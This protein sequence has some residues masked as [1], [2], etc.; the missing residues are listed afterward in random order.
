MTSDRKLYRLY[1]T[2]LRR[3]LSTIDKSRGLQEINQGLREDVSRLDE[4]Q[5]LVEYMDQNT[6]LK[7]RLSLFIKSSDPKTFRLVLLDKFIV[8][9]VY[10]YVKENNSIYDKDKLV[11]LFRDLENTLKKELT[12]IIQ[13][14]SSIY[15]RK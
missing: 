13:R 10:L 8:R 4:S 12:S 9:F 14:L 11:T 7:Q 5:K 3:Y 1:S 6:K 2:M 15:S